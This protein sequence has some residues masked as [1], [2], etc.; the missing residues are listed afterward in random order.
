MATNK[1]V[2]IGGES[3]RSAAE[4]TH[5]VPPTVMENRGAR[6][7]KRWGEGEDCLFL[8]TQ[9]SLLISLPQQG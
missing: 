9:R 8:V 3:R 5:A 7:E 6:D 1:D 4:G 2:C